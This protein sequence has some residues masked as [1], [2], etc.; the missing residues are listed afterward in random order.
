MPNRQRQYDEWDAQDGYGDA[1]ADD[2][3]NDTYYEDEQY[4]GE[5]EDGYE[6]APYAGDDDGGLMLQPEQSL[7][8]VSNTITTHGVPLLSYTGTMSR[9]YTSRKQRLSLGRFKCEVCGERIR[10]WAW[11]TNNRKRTHDGCY[12]RLAWTWTNLYAQQ[13]ALAARGQFE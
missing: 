9:F 2:A 10:F 7:V 4:A 1:Q 13:Q 5:A 3:Y 6:I 8:G 12:E 11:E